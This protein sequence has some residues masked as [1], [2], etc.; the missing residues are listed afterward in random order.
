MEVTH[1]HKED[2]EVVHFVNASGHFGNSF[3][4][5]ALLTDQSVMIPWKKESAVCENL[6]EPGNVCWELKDQKL[7]I[8]LPRLGAHACVVVHK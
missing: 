2:F 3:F 8:T 4:D 5:P 1:G 6:D 7:T